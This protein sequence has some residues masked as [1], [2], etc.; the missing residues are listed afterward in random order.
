[1]PRIDA[2]GNLVVR[3]EGSEQGLKPILIGSHSDTVPSGGRYDGMLG[4]LGALEVAQSLREA[5]RK[6]R[7]PLEIV[8]FLAEEPSEFGLSCVGSRAMAGTLSGD[9]LALT[10]SSDGITLRQALREVGGDPD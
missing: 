7:H 3:L 5:N 9:M 6:L 1:E 2:G 4:L 10:R 8:D